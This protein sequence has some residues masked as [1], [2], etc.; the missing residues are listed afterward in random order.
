LPLRVE[1]E[2]CNLRSLLRSR[3]AAHRS[4]LRSPLLADCALGYGAAGLELS[5]ALPLPPPQFMSTDDHF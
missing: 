5:C 3:S 2:F 4:T 1:S